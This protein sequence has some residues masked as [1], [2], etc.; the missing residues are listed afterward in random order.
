MT[1]PT[2]NINKTVIA[3]AHD[4]DHSGR[5]ATGRV[6]LEDGEAFSVVV[7]VGAETH[8][9][10]SGTA[11]AKA[12]KLCSVYVRVRGEADVD[13]PAPAPEIEEPIL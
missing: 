12:G 9:M 11:R 1:R 3:K 8:V 7:K 13:E 5:N 4:E 10:A 6:F 2:S